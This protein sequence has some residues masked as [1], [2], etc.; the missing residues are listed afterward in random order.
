MPEG[1]SVA[2][3]GDVLRNLVGETVQHV[4]VPARWRAAAEQIVGARLTNVV[5]HGKHLVLEFSSDRIIHAHAMQYGSWQVGER[6]QE[7]RK[8]RRFARLI[9]TTTEHEA[10]FFHGPVMEVLTRA[11]FAEHERFHSLGPDL[12]KEGFSERE[13]LASLKAQKKREIGDA[14]LDQRIVAGIGNIY[15]SEG[16]FLAGIHP[17]RESQRI[18]LG[19]LRTFFYELIPLMQQA[20]LT[21]GRTLT[22]PEELRFELWMT[23]WVYRR[24]GHPCFVCSTPVEMVR[25]GEFQRATYYCPV[26]Q[27]D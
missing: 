14:I 2:R 8:D 21:Y 6:G 16:L 18:S 19:E 20:R 5:T 25:Q 26:C 24:R 4:Q 9:L 22:L 10:V 17:R 27:P 12:L 23:N 1:H 13:V 3:W 7:L 11:E 15:K